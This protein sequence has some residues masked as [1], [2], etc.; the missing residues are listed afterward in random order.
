MI[1]GSLHSGSRIPNST[2]AVHHSMTMRCVLI[3]VQL[4]KCV[5]V[6]GSVLHSGHSGGRSL[7][8]SILFKY[9]CRVGHLFVLC[10]AR[11]L[12]VAALGVL[13]RN[14]VCNFV[15]CS[16]VE[17]CVDYGGVYVFHVCFDLCVVYGV[18]VCVDVCGVVCV[19][20]CSMFLASGCCLL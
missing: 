14:D 19:V 8:S 6:Y 9:E 15:V 13:F 10:C 5:V 3:L 16:V 2:G 7:Y 4:N 17:I 20:E 1:G 12:R 18:G 11:V